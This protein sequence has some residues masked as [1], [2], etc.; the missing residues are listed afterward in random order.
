MTTKLSLSCL[1]TVALVLTLSLSTQV[2]AQT[3]PDTGGR[4]FGLVGG[5]FGDG[6]TAVLTSGGAGVR[7]TRNL[8]LDFEVFHVTG[9]DLSERDQFFIQRLSIA[10]PFNI[11]RD[12]GV[13][14]FTS[15]ITAD[16][17]V[18][19][20]LIPYVTG[21]GGVGHLSETISYNFG[22]P[23]PENPFIDLPIL[24]SGRPLIFPPEPFEVSESGLVLTVGGGVDVR[25]WK[26]LALGGEVKWLRLLANRGDFDYAQVATRVSYRF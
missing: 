20:R 16:F 12:G 23:F 24:L 6:G 7:L 4:V 21:G 10:P 5:S 19:D 13:T 22:F 15:K 11:K 2:E 25:L 14:A 9:L 1:S 3:I 17:P 18:G 8:G 26:G